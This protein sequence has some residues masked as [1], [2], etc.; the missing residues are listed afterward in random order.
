M[1]DGRTDLQL[2]ARLKCSELDGEREYVGR[3]LTLGC[4]SA[5]SITSISTQRGGNYGPTGDISVSG[6]F[7]QFQ[8]TFICSLLK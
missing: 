6:C 1:F 7:S 3:E 5:E 2:Q 4:H 8:T